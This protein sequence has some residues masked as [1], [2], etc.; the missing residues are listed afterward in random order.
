[1]TGV[2][3]LFGSFTLLV[4]IGMPIAFCF[5][6]SSVLTMLYLGLNASLLSEL[7]FEG[8]NSYTLMA[9]PFF[10]IVG[11]LL[12]HTRIADRLLELADALV[13]HIRGGLALVNTLTSMIFAGMSGTATADV[14]ASGSVVMPAMVKRGYDL[15]FTIALT[16]TTATIGV[17]IPPSISMI[18]YGSSTNVS[19]GGLFMAGVIPGVFL[20]AALMLY[21]Y[22]FAVRRGM[23]GSPRATVSQT[24]TAFGRAFVPLWIPFILVGGVA[25]GQFTATE[26]GVIGVVLA[27]CLGLAYRTMKLSDLPAL[28]KE[29]A[30]ISS[31]ALFIVSTAVTFGW[32]ISYLEV[33]YQIGIFLG[34]YADNQLVILLFLILVFLFLGTA[35]DSIP[36]IIVMMPVVEHL[37]ET[38][39]ANPIHTGLVIIMTLAM[40]HITPPTGNPLFLAC[41]IMNQPMPKVIPAL[42]PFYFSYLA[43]VVI[44]A[45]VPD[46]ALFLPRYFLGAAAG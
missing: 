25:S 13:G 45:M 11:S 21:S 31:L 43:V 35:M 30:L 5:G 22:F 26:C 14:A 34:D 39:G 36:A 2:A 27:F 42:V 28:L 1:M 23:V 20:G 29:S 7:M 44:V 19:I 37:V 8:L 41:K 12:N 4:L 10:L 16:A 38:S 15:N 46:I 9:A 3:I 6:I 18:V 40:G 17:I 24:A 32:L 33:P